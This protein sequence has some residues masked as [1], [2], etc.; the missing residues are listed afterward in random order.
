MQL[1]LNKMD[2]PFK[3]VQTCAV[4]VSFSLAFNVDYNFSELISNRFNHTSKDV[5]GIN[6]LSSLVK[7]QF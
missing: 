1:K 7:L 4:A 2:A 6:A 3:Q 5:I